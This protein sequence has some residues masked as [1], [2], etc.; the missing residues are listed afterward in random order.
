MVFYYRI[1]CRASAIGLVGDHAQHPFAVA[2]DCFNA[3]QR[4]H[5]RAVV[6]LRP[7][8]ASAKLVL[9]DGVLVGCRLCA[10]ISPEDLYC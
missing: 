1:V 5:S 10:Q 9:P 3:G 7:S 8:A 6:F 2:R 4:T